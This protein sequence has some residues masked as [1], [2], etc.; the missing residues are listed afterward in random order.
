L[1]VFDFG[2][3]D[4]QVNS[5]SGWCCAFEFSCSLVSL[6]AHA[7][8]LPWY[9]RSE[10]CRCRVAVELVSLV[11]RSALDRGNA[12]EKRISAGWRGLQGKIAERPTASVSHRENRKLFTAAEEAGH[13]D[14][15][16]P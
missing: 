4:R 15:Y 3:V 10:S 7:V 11:S 12:K 14:R 5:Q 13:D 1:R 16:W 2:K 8:A 9:V 6:A